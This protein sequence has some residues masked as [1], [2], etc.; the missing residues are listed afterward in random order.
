MVKRPRAEAASA[1]SAV[2]DWWALG[3]WQTAN[4][5]R[6]VAQRAQLPAVGDLVTCRVQR[7]NPRM[8]TV[9]ILCVGDVALR[10]ACSGLIRREVVRPTGMESIEVYR[11]FRPGDIVIARVLSLGDARAYYLSSSEAELGVVLARSSEGAVMTPISHCEMECPLTKAREN[12]KVAKPRQ[13][14]SNTVTTDEPKV[15]AEVDPAGKAQAEP[16]PKPAAASATRKKK[17]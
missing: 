2:G 4:A 3:E 11:S 15:M 6:R 17:T 7:I 9:E 13:Q 12:R 10:E 16:P 1:S 8:A 14:E 5:R